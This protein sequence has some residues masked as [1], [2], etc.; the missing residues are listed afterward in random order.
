MNAIEQRQEKNKELIVEQLKK[1]PIIQIACEKVGVARATF[2]RWRK[3][4]QAFGA[5]VDQALSEGSSLINDLAESQLISAIKQGNMTGLIYWL[6]HHHS[7]YATRI[8]L[9]T[10]NKSQEELTPEQ[11]KLIKRAVALGGFNDQ[12]ALPEKQNNGDSKQHK[13]AETNQQQPDN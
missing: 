8:E 12:L 4:D 3:A 7:A 9:S 2:Y 11:E 6:K 5:A 13:P 10:V 1:A